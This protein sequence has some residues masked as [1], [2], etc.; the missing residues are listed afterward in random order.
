VNDL[1][2]GAVSKYAVVCIAD[3][4]VLDLMKSASRIDHEE[5]SREIVVRESAMWKLRCL[6]SAPLAHKERIFS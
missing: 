2:P 5:A 4:I 6:A 3:E 1:E